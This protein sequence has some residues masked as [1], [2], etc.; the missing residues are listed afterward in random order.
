MDLHKLSKIC[1]TICV[2][3]IVL[4]VVLAL[5][6]IWGDVKDAVMWKAG[7]TV[8]V[9]FGASLLTMNVIKALG[10]RTKDSQE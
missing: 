9:F 3:C 5:V 4:G 8:A 7:L 10:S 1:F 2:V 6:C